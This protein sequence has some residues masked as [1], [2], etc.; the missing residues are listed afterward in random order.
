MP[1][2]PGAQVAGADAP[3]SAGKAALP[4][5]K[6]DR[7]HCQSTELAAATYALKSRN[8]TCYF[9]DLVRGEMAPGRIA[10]ILGRGVVNRLWRLFSSQKYFER[11]GGKQKSTTSVELD[12]KPGDLV[13]VK[14]LAEIKETLDA[15]GRNRGMSFE[16]EMS[17]H[18]GKR[19]RVLAPIHKMISEETGKMVTLNNTVLLDGLTCEG[20]CGANC[21][22]PITFFGAN[23]GSNA[24][25]ACLT[26]RTSRSM[27]AK[28][29]TV[30]CRW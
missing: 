2:G 23:A 22:A 28:G 19:F 17:R 27:A 12:L 5:I 4:T 15:N 8:I 11:M 30:P 25:R 26:A 7:Y 24:L 1:A 21:P 16:P 9:H 13:E 29:C 6:D 18:C 10:Y 20:I 3:P 14:S